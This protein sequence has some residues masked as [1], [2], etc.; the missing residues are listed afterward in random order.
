MA[1]RRPIPFLSLAAAHRTSA[2]VPEL[3][4]MKLRALRRDRAARTG[5]ELF[6]FD[7][8]FADCLERMAL[9]NRPFER[10]LLI[11]CP[12]PGWA[13][14]LRAIAAEV[15]VRDPGPQFANAA[16]GDIII[17]DA[18][19]PDSQ[20]YDLVVAIGTLDT[21]NDLPLA[22]RLIGYAMRPGGLFIGA[23]SGGDT[24]PEL[25]AAM[26]AADALA[27]VAAP[28]VHPRIE[29]SA[30]S[31]LLA[32]AGFERPVV[33]VE[34]VRVSYRSFERLVGDLRAMGATNILRS[35][36]P[37]LARSHRTAASRAFAERA[38][39]GRT[40]ETFEIIHFAAWV[41]QSG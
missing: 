1:A 31:S 11:G 37:S 7:R 14:R 39:E 27:G 36:A 9:M 26:R 22:L 35:K 38:V 16:G 24:L 8:V 20:A 41:G 18:W 6:L 15:D 40:T 5:L 17:E 10:A 29:A 13:E 25:R 30:L 21:V 28:H 12:D 23:V 32:D 2:V 3:F 34:R 4:D 19:E 33:D